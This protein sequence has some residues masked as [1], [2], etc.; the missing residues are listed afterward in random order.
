VLAGSVGTIDAAVRNLVA[1]GVPFEEAVAAATIVPAR[2]AG[3]PE[4][5]VL[6]PGAP[7][8]LV[9]LDDRLEVARVLTGR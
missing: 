7:A 3:R 4:L 9:V 6:A 5:A 8:R 1:L 2:I